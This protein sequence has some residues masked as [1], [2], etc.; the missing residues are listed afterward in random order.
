MN[1]FHVKPNETIKSM[2]KYLWSAYISNNCL[3]IRLFVQC[4][5]MFVYYCRKTMWVCAVCYCRNQVRDRECT[6]CENE[7]DCE[8]IEGK[9]YPKTD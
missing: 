6:E 7:K 1:L 4:S 9:Y 3:K 5:S 8:K 2:S